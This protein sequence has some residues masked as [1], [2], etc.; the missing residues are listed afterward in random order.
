MNKITVIF[1]II[2]GVATFAPAQTKPV[3]NADLE[4]YRTQR[5]TAEKD[6]RENYAKLGFPSPEELE[7]QAAQD[8][9]E[10]E[11]LAEKLRDARLERERIEAERQRLAYD[12]ARAA[13]PQI[14]VEQQDQYGFLIGYSLF[15][16]RR[17]PWRSQFPFRGNIIGWRATGGGLI[18]VPGGSSFIRTPVLRPHRPVFH[19][20]RRR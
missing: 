3:T 10:R 19:G 12:A 4:K 1:V 17:H 9:K 18:Y 14:I 8:A 13:Q 15:G 2:L 5:L 20:P 11:A 16:G 6:L 7:K